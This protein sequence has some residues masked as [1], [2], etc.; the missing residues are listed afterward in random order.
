MA[1]DNAQRCADI[2]KNA[3]YNYA[4][5][6]YE[7]HHRA[8]PDWNIYGSETSSIV[9]SRGIYHFPAD[10][11]ILCE[12]DEQCSALG[13]SSPAW[14]SRSWEHNLISDR[15]AEFCAGQ[16][17]WTG[18]DYIGE[19][20]PYSTKNSYFGQIDTAGFLKDSAYVYK[21]VWTD[22]RK[23]PFV[24]IFPYWDFNEGEMI[25]VLV[26]TNCFE[27]KLYFNGEELASKV[28]GERPMQ[29]TMKK[30]LP[31]SKGELVA[32]AYD[33]N[34]NEL[35]RDVQRSFSET[36]EIR[37]LPDRQSIACG[38][39]ELIFVEISAYDSDGNF[40]ANGW[41]I[42][43]GRQYF[44]S[45]LESIWKYMLEQIKLPLTKKEWINYCIDSTDWELN[46][47]DPVS[48]ILPMC[49]YDFDKRESMIS[50]ARLYAT[51]NKMVENG[52]EVVLSMYNRF[53]DRDDFGEESALL[54]KGNETSSISFDELI[55]VVHRYKDRSVREFSVYV[56]DNWLIEQHRRTAFEKL[57]QGRDGFYFEEIDGNYIYKAGFDINFQGIRLEQL[58]QVMKDLNML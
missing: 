17:I 43:V 29:L 5:R 34:G 39:E 8:H 32:I 28:F 18:F 55:E 2:L 41:E 56:M 4:E 7:E 23:D 58:T 22:S 47:D 19:L 9:Q 36:A 40:V 16:F 12:D 35:A 10:K 21:A 1:S 31:Y 33:E 24:H 30:T 57:M 38:S 49:N 50:D 42:V 53:V 6:L 11:D 51:P 13:N 25:D 44:T 15:D 46:I 26:T 48:E 37:L 3:G 27:A 20:T 54:T 52:L 45:G 14:A